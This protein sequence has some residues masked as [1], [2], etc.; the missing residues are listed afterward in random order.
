MRATIL[1]V[2]M[3]PFLAVGF[4]WGVI[5]TAFGAGTMAAEKM[6]GKT[7]ETELE[8]LKSGAA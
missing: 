5:S 8:K 4:V 3:L 2:F 1:M 7:A 6:L